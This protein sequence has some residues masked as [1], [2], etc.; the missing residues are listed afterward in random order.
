GQVD[1]YCH[2][3]PGV[4]SRLDELQAA[5]LRA[6]LPWLPQW[7]E[8]RR[9]LA[10]RYRAALAHTDRVDIPPECDA[11]HVYHLFVVRTATRRALQAHLEAHGIQ[12]LV[13]YPV[14]IPRQRALADAGPVVCPVADRVCEE[15]LSLPLYPALAD[16]SVTTVAGHIASFGDDH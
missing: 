5:I 13:H 12:T 14:P 3:E 15:V 9:A 4:N 10:A 6:R 1:R 2:H 8:R 7:T 11:G 16:E